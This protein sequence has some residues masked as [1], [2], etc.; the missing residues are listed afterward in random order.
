[1]TTAPTISPAAGLAWPPPVA[2]RRALCCARRRLHALPM[3]KRPVLSC[4]SSV[5]GLFALPELVVVVTK[6]SIIT[7]T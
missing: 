7:M 1:M 5:V 6:Y 4:P 2:V 3:T